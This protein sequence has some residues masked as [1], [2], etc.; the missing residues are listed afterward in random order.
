MQDDPSTPNSMFLNICKKDLPPELKELILAYAVVYV[1][2]ERKWKDGDTLKK[3][4]PQEFEFFKWVLHLFCQSPKLII[5][6]EATET[7]HKK[8]RA[9]ARC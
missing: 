5:E 7:W 9:F 1:S 3:S 4:F 2:E 8:P 6:V